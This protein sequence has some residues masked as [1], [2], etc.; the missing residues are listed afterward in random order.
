MPEPAVLRYPAK[1]PLVV[2][3]PLAALG[4]RVGYRRVYLVGMAL[5][6]LA[7]VG[8]MLAASMPALIAARALQGL[9]AAGVMAVNAALVRL[10]YPRAQLGHGMAIN[11]LV[12]ATAS[13]A[14]FRSLT[15]TAK[16]MNAT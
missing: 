4:E 6:A 1:L 12:V 14:G 13:M 16:P 3:L 15:P 9:G 8:A 2:L 11:S 5:F 10:I 7:S